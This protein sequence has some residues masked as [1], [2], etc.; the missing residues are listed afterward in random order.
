MSDWLTRSPSTDPSSLPVWEERRSLKLQQ[1][2]EPR[3]APGDKRATPEE[4]QVE[5]SERS[6]RWHRA[7]GGRLAEALLRSGLENLPSVGEALTQWLAAARQS[8]RAAVLSTLGS[9]LAR[10]LTTGE[11][12][13]VAATEILLRFEWPGAEDLLAQRLE[14]RPLNE[15]HRYAAA[16]CRLRVPSDLFRNRLVSGLESA[17]RDSHAQSLSE[18]REQSIVVECVRSLAKIAPRRLVVENATLC[19]QVPGLAQTAVLDAFAD[20]LRTTREAALPAEI[21][22]AQVAA[23]RL[24]EILKDYECIDNFTG[25]AA[26]LVEISVRAGAD[27]QPLLE[28]VESHSQD[29]RLLFALSSRSVDYLP[30]DLRERL[31]SSAVRALMSRGEPQSAA[32]VL[33]A[34]ARDVPAM[35][36]TVMRLAQGLKKEDAHT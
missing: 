14:L 10:G 35:L 26:R 2:V 22:L 15:F 8:A 28:T 18:R 21:G 6:A 27:A 16:F 7:E 24:A 30:K 17:L 20:A 23:G 5:R 33:S 36:S 13:S 12:N 1:R 19:V 32:A 11:D 34:A 3:P 31:Y 4:L 25:V 29:A 9:S